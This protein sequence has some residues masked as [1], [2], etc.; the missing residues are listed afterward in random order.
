[1]GS[2]LRILSCIRLIEPHRRFRWAVCQLD[3]LRRLKTAA[4]VNAALDTLPETLDETY[5]RI[6]SIIPKYYKHI[7]RRVLV[8]LCSSSKLRN[9]NYTAY[10][11]ISS[12]RLIATV[13]SAADEHTRHPDRSMSYTEMLRD[14]CGCLVKVEDGYQEKAFHEVSEDDPEDTLDER[15]RVSLAH[16]TVAEFILSPRSS[17]SPM[18]IVANFAIAWPDVIRE[19]GIILLETTITY[20]KAPATGMWKTQRDLL[21]SASNFLLA[22]YEA[23]CLDDWTEREISNLPP[24]IWEFASLDIVWYTNNW[25]Q[26][27]RNSFKPFQKDWHGLYVFLKIFMFGFPQLAMMSLDRMATSLVDFGAYRNLLGVLADYT[28]AESFRFEDIIFRNRTARNSEMLDNIL[29]RIMDPTRFLILRLGSHCHTFRCPIKGLSSE[30]C[31]LVTAL[32]KGANPNCTQYGKTPLQLAVERS[33]DVAVR[34][35]LERGADPNLVG[36]EDGD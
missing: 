12:D 36:A 14:I 30:E 25:S 15:S 32:D 10:N 26:Q 7:V 8:I 5:E 16:C 22:F 34:L 4:Q 31:P 23:Q 21:T 19:Y 28:T 27:F 3:V 17:A 1:M 29:L 20:S 18:P 6:L 11:R 35:L 24:L 33:D 2:Y 13:L 9:G